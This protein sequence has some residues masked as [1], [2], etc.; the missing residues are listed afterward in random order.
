MVSK[1][2]DSMRPKKAKCYHTNHHPSP[3]NKKGK[4]IDF[5]M[6]SNPPKVSSRSARKVWI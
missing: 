5:D 4:K 1:A 2:K 6:K 3:T